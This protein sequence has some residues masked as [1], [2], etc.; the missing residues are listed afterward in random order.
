MRLVNGYHFH[1]V[2]FP[3]LTS[4]YNKIKFNL[5][6]VLVCD[7]DWVKAPEYLNLMNVV[8]SFPVKISPESLPPGV[9]YTR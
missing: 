9:H 6:L 5:K 2:N 7:A 8:R 1:L 4:N 3:G